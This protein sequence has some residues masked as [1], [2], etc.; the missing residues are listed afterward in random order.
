MTEKDLEPVPAPEEHRNQPHTHVRSDGTEYKHSHGDVPHTHSHGYSHT[1]TRTVIN[2]F[3]RAIGHLNSVKHMVETGRD[4]TEVL[5]QLAAVQS[6]LNG[7]AKVVLK[8]HIEHCLTDAISENDTGA[9][10]E[11]NAAIERFMR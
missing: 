1:Q 10:E 8:D 3:S 4:C 5:M 7:I 9:I 11:L 2:R 6:A